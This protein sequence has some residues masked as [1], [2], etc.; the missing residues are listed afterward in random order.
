MLRNVAADWDKWL[1]QEDS[2]NESAP[3]GY[4]N[5]A[6]L[7]RVELLRQRL[8]SSLA[9]YEVG[10]SNPDWY[11][12]GT[13]LVSYRV[14][15]KGDSGPFAPALAWVLLSR[16]G[17]LATVKG[18][19]D[20]ELLARLGSELSH[21]GLNYIPYGYVVDK[22]YDGKCKALVG[23]SWANRYFSLVADHASEANND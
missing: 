3:E 6:A 22:A 13:G 4:D 17:H 7:A 2:A 20:P 9:A 16:F 12:D 5:D 23:F 8:T 19:D 14:T 18:C 15:A 1:A 11:Q 10:I 21:F